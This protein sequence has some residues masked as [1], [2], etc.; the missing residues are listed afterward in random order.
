MVYTKQKVGA[1]VE[2]NRKHT[3]VLLLGGRLTT[4]A[5]GFA[6]GF[7]VAGLAIWAFLMVS[8]RG[9][10]SLLHS[11]DDI[12]REFGGLL[13]FLG[14]AVVAA[15]AG[16]VIARAHARKS[17]VELQIL[18]IERDTLKERMRAAQVESSEVRM[19]IEELRSAQ[20]TKGLLGPLVTAEGP[21]ATTRLPVDSVFGERMGHFRAEKE[22]LADVLVSVVSTRAQAL[23]EEGNKNVVI[24]V[25][26]GTTLY[27][28]FEK[29][30]RMIAQR[31]V[32]DDHAKEKGWWGHQIRIVTNSIAGIES[33]IL[34]GRTSTEDRYSEI[35]GNAEIV[36]GTPLAVYSASVGPLAIR[37]IDQLKDPAPRDVPSRA[38]RI[39]YNKPIHIIAL[40]TGNYIF[41]KPDGTPVPVARGEGH[42][43]FKAAICKNA[44]EI[45]V[46]GPLG[47][48]IIE[49][50]N[51]NLRSLNAD[52]H[53]TPHHFLGGR[54][55][56]EEVEL[57]EP[58]KIRALTTYR[59]NKAHVF[60][61]HSNQVRA[62]LG[63]VWEITAPEQLWG[64]ELLGRITDP[65]A[66]IA[67][68]MVDFAQLPDVPSAQLLVELP[69]RNMRD[70]VLRRK[71]F[72]IDI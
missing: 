21:V 36:A 2:R 59:S 10:L 5:F 11:A 52:L 25:D 9:I 3:G 56:Y 26:S 69:H 45:F 66:L 28:F 6:L 17:D 58:G 19:I 60:F 33:L 57:Q 53:H 49:D 24:I 15:I 27:P 72:Q 62:K 29:F 68:V 8:D 34:N 31:A 64:P 48:F 42:K 20:H 38:D 18:N 51:V 71:Y 35:A 7:L 43:D 47:K 23:F 67:N 61:A 4:L 44:D 37:H 41:L 50:A 54:R 13:G 63:E 14:G 1:V 22:V 16:A 70:P 65:N 40:T 12:T 30:G 46:V 55:P 32:L 39:N